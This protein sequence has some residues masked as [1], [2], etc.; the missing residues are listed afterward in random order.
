MCCPSSDFSRIL[1]LI[2]TEVVH[3]EGPKMQPADTKGHTEK[4]RVVG[5]VSPYVHLGKL[6]ETKKKANVPLDP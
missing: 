2:E 5:E 3:F 4:M 6:H 1:F